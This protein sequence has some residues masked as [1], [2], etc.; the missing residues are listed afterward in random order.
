[1][2]FKLDHE[3]D[4]GFAIVLVIWVLG[5]LAVLAASVAAD[6]RSEAVIARNRLNVAQARCLADAG[7]ALAVAGLLEADPAAQWHAD[8]SAVTV[9]YGGSSISIV[10]QDEGGK[11]DLNT[12]PIELI[13]GLLGEFGASG[14]EVSAVTSGIL[15]R[16]REFAA[17][18][19]PR[20]NRF[21]FLTRSY[22]A[23]V[24]GQ[25]F[26][27]ASELRLIPG[28]SRSTFEQVAPFVTVYSGTPTINP[29]TAPRAVLLGVPAMNPQDVD[30]YLAARGQ[31]GVE[32]PL[33]AT[34]NR[35][36]G[37][38]DLHA[39]SIIARVSTTGGASFIREAIVMISPSF[40]LQPYRIMHWGQ[41]LDAAAR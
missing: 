33:V 36:I 11:V 35:Y 6:W 1:M 4:R 38:G 34:V 18:S 12:A 24:S 26:A 23:D 40:P 8:G 7:V 39:A 17:R 25:P 29:A 32:R 16:R 20:S 5:L 13:A 31:A 27:D 21:L 14:A 28:M 37:I 3:D 2:S 15:D 30:T 41:A 9:N 19:S 22:S 10:V